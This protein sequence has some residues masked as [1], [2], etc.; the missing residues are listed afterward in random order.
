LNPLGIDKRNHEIGKNGKSKMV[1]LPSS[2]GA[3]WSKLCEQAQIKKTTI[4]S[5]L[6]RSFLR[7]HNKDLLRNGKDLLLPSCFG[8]C[9]AMTLKEYIEEKPLLTLYSVRDIAH[10]HDSANNNSS[11][12]NAALAVGEQIRILPPIDIPTKSFDTSRT[13]F[14]F[15]GRKPATSHKT[16]KP[17]RNCMLAQRLVKTFSVRTV[18][19]IRDIHRSRHSHCLAAH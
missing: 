13:Q 5:N 6:R 18:G 19:F 11:D 12:M 14:V 16:C 17:C 15:D 4:K 2:L 8:G 1:V 3:A 7:A 10:G 9:G